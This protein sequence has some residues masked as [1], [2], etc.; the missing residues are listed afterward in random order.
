ML[1]MDISGG[2]GAGRDPSHD[3]I[4]QDSEKAERFVYIDITHFGQTRGIKDDKK[5]NILR[6]LWGKNHR[7]WQ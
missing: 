3:S 4:V 1:S 5:S 7:S 6:Y 2:V